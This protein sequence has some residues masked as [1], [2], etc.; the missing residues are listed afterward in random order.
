[1]SDNDNLTKRIFQEMKAILGPK[2]VEAFM[3]PID[4][5][6][7]KYFEGNK[8]GTLYKFAKKQ[9]NVHILGQIAE[10]SEEY[11][12]KMGMS[13]SVLSS[14]RK[15][16]FKA[17]GLTLGLRDQAL[18]IIKAKSNE[19]ASTQNKYKNLFGG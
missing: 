12:K 18:D 3:T 7:E 9:P 10:H 1:M 6:P 2:G 14:L 13:D 15:D 11:Y 8:E 4:E 16:L 5:A 17:N 19:V